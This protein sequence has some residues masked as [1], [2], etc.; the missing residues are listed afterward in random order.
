MKIKTA[1]KI[2]GLLAVLMISSIASA[3]PISLPVDSVNEAGA[4]WTSID[5]NPAFNIG[6]A[7]IPSHS[8][9][10]D[11]FFLVT[12]NNVDYIPSSSAD[13]SNIS[14]EG[15]PFGTAITAE[16]IAIDGLNVTGQY[17][18]FSNL[19]GGSPTARLLVAIEN[20]TAVA[21][22]AEVFIYGNLGSDESTAKRYSS[23]GDT[24]FFNNDSWIVTSDNPT[25][26]S[27]PAVAFIAQGP[28]CLSSRTDLA[29][30][31]SDNLITRFTFK[32]APGE[33]KRLA[34]FVQLNSTNELAATGAAVFSSMTTVNAANL[35]GD[36]TSEV[37]ATIANFGF[38]DCQADYRALVSD[39]IN[40]TKK[41]SVGKGGKAAKSATQLADSHVDTFAGELALRTDKTVDELILSSE[42]AV[43]AVNAAA[44]AAKRSESNFVPLK[45]K[46][47]RAL[48]KLI[49][50]IVAE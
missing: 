33:T 14:V 45:S 41:L 15:N 9:A 13:Q 25:T 47:L 34:S 28:S 32:L 27:D 20:P 21:R 12:V 35:F 49:N 36:L 2:K 4:T 5:F 43:K 7:S 42:L 48:K 17:L 31:I 44:L 16:K 8:D 3:T 19:V 24:S 11:E 29:I 40:K 46:A 38:T 37:K 23:S 30:Q 22:T 39:A 10:F 6:D 26:P 18:F 1:I 50:K